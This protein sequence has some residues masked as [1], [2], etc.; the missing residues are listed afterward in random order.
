MSASGV[1]VVG[2]LVAAGLAGAPGIQFVVYP[3][4]PPTLPVLA[5]TGILVGLAPAWI[6][7]V[8]RRP[9]GRP[10]RAGLRATATAGPPVAAADLGGRVA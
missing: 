8:E 10:A 1:V 6:A 9:P 2:C 5:A 3:L 4:G 7:P